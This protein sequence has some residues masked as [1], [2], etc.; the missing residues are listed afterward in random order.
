MNHFFM[1]AFALFFISAL[2]LSTQSAFAQGGMAKQLQ[3]RF[4]A[5]DKDH[6]GKLT[7]SE[8]KA[9]M[10][11]VAQ[12]FEKIDTENTGSITLAQIEAFMAQQQ[13]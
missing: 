2:V 4:S 13:R 12:F 1:R 5:A 9:G 3:A 8:A 6:D 7:K 10:P 11:R